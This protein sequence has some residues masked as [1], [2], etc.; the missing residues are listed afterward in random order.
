MTRSILVTGGGRGIG[1]AVALR[2]AREGF[3]V[4][5]MARSGK[6]LAETAAAVGAA[7][8]KALA[9]EGDVAKEAD[10]ETAVRRC[11][12]AF[13]G[14]DVLVN[15]AGLFRVK[16]LHETSTEMWRQILETNLTGAF[17]VT[18]AAVRCMAA[19]RRGRAIVNVSS[20]AG[21]RGFPG[22]G[23]YCASKFGL[24]GFGDAIR[25]ELRPAGIRVINVLPGQVDTAAWDG[26]GLDLGKLGI[27]RDRMMKP[28]EVADAIARAVL[29]DGAAVAE[30]ILLK[31]I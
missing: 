11:D 31:P 28:E 10:A 17:L 14:L 16:P 4:A 7:G 12:E 2:F 30:E 15:N 20:E 19:R 27:R 9:L 13:G 22:S 5:V 25:E 29:A 6:E 26:C 23:A 1:R 24:C 18:R 8:G 21:K 3:G